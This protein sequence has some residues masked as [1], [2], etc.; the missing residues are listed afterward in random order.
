MRIAGRRVGTGLLGR[1]YQLLLACLGETL[2]TG[3]FGGLFLSYSVASHLHSGQ[4]DLDNA[5]GP[6]SAC[7]RR[8]P[9]V[10]ATGPVT[11]RTIHRTN[12][13]FRGNIQGDWAWNQ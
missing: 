4:A 5:T 1:I 6:G 2:V 10:T 13:G 12:S 8:R 9:A 3:R 11:V 7:W